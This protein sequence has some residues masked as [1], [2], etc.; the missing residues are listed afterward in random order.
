VLASIV[1]SAATRASQIERLREHSRALVTAAV[2]GELEIPGVAA[3]R[4]RGHP[5]AVDVVVVGL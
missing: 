2:S 3:M 1:K 4:V 5:G